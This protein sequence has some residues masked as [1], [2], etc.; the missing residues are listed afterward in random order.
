[1]L[2]LESGVSQRTVR[3]FEKGGS[4]SLDNLLSL[5]RVLRMLPNLDAFMAKEIINPFDI[6]DR[7]H[8]RKRASSK[9]HGPKS[10]WEW[11]DD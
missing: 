3:G 4:I 1:M 7:G 2:A 6:L 8:R 10:S 5:F 9:V 11:E